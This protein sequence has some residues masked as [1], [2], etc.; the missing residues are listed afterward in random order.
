MLFFTLIIGSVA[1]AAE[2][3]DFELQKQAED[4]SLALEATDDSTAGR[5]WAWDLIRVRTVLELGVEI[6]V[7]TKFSINPEVEF[8]FVKK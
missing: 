4:L 2:T 7:I 6:P 5:A 3:P 8:H 1:M